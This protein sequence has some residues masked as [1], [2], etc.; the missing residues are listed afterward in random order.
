MLEVLYILLSRQTTSELLG[1]L[2]DI[3]CFGKLMTGGVIPLA[4]T[5]ATEAVFDSFA[6]DSKVSICCLVYLH[7]RSK[8]SVFFLHSC[9]KE[10]NLELFCFN[11][12][13]FM[14]GVHGTMNLMQRLKSF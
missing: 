5:L 9:P 14:I 3:A 7:E 13:N 8:L 6:G 1:V 4:A 11:N 2:P 12:R 10:L